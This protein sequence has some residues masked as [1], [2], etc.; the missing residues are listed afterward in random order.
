MS[1][2][3]RAFWDEVHERLRRESAEWTAMLARSGIHFTEPLSMPK[4]PAEPP[5]DHRADAVRERLEAKM[6]QYL[7]FGDSCTLREW[8]GA[9]R[10]WIEIGEEARRRGLYL[11]GD[12]WPDT[13][14]GNLLAGLALC[15]VAAERLR[16]DPTKE[17]WN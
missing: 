10:S 6:R 13:P 3:D 11:P 15:T 8:R 2:G 12:A 17:P 4:K 14:S 1:V 9:G 16:E 7:T 5:I